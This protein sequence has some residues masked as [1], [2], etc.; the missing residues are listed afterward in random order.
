MT[1]NIYTQQCMEYTHSSVDI[2]DGLSQ[3]DF[4]DEFI[5]AE[6]PYSEGDVFSIIPYIGSGSRITISIGEEE[7]AEY[8]GFDGFNQEIVSKIN[9]QPPQP[10]EPGEAKLLWGHDMKYSTDFVWNS[11]GEFDKAKLCFLFG[12]DQLGEI[13]LEG[14]KYDNQSPDNIDEFI[15]PGAGYTDIQFFY[16]PNQVWED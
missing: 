13:Y 1:I 4:E 12:K 16:H 11:V 2:P 8:T 14:L 15:D 7:V 5:S 6:D 10:K 9:F 3:C